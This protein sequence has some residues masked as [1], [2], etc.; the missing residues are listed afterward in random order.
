[1]M[2][3][4]T[5]HADRAA[6]MRQAFDRTFAEPP[7]TALRETESFLAVRLGGDPYAI[8][9]TESVGMFA[10]REITWLPSPVA[11]LRGI[12]GLRGAVL[13]VYDLGALLGYPAT[14]SARWLVVARSVAV[15]FAFDVFDGHLR[16]DRE[17]LVAHDAAQREHVQEVA[18]D[19][20]LSYPIIHL[21]SVLAALRA[22]VPAEPNRRTVT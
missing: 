9:L 8:R 13:P 6:E 3:G 2:D 5:P 11:E 21:P 4:Q 7:Q 17:A 14:S 18:R 10:D 12:A 19:N 15:A 20:G 1:M 22:R 16:V